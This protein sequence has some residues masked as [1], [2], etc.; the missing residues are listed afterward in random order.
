VREGSKEYERDANHA[1]GYDIV[2]DARARDLVRFSLLLEQMRGRMAHERMADN[3]R[4]HRFDQTLGHLTINGVFK[5]GAK[6]RLR[7]HDDA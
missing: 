2:H 6:E 5:S 7:C 4:A 3:R 1:F